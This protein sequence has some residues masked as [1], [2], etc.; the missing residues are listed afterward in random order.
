MKAGA[1]RYWHAPEGY[2]STLAAF[3]GAEA[4]LVFAGA[5]SGAITPEFSGE[6][7][8]KRI[9]SKLNASPLE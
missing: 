4:A 5:C 2:L 1:G 8:T 3:N 7:S 9:R 6:Q